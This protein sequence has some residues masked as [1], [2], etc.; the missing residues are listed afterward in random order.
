MMS[1]GKY[2][3]T[4]DSDDF[5]YSIRKLEKEMKII[6][7]NSRKNRDVIAFSYTIQGKE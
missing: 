7:S 1:R 3:T 2:L 4:L 5:Y 6:N